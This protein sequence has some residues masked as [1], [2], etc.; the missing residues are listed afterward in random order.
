MYKVI[1]V[2]PQLNAKLDAVISSGSTSY[3]FLPPFAP[4]DSEEELKVLNDKAMDPQF[5]TKT[6]EA[7]AYMYGRNSTAKGKDVGYVII[8]RFGTRKLFTTCTWTGSSS[9][10][11][12]FCLSKYIG[13]IYLIEAV[14][15]YSVPSW[16]SIENQNFLVK[17]IMSNA[18]VRCNQ[19]KITRRLPYN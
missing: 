14:I 9:R 17:C 19:K 4:V 8:D 15:R 3:V 16:T 11:R 10:Y 18:G 2:L 12:K 13:F 7:F 6:I 5:I 1:N